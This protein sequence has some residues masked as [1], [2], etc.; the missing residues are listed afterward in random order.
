[1]GFTTSG[2][3]RLTVRWRCGTLVPRFANA[4]I[5]EKGAGLVEEVIQRMQGS[6]DLYPGPGN[7]SVNFFTAHEALRRTIWLL[8]MK[9]QRGHLEDNKMDI[10]KR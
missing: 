9:A 5:L 7:C 6:P 1:M 8:S 2:R 10:R 3:S 4:Q